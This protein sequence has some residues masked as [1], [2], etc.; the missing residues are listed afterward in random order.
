ME[1]AGGA[2]VVTGAGR[3]TGRTIAL[4]FG[5]LGARVALVARTESE[6]QETARQ[7]KDSGGKALVAPADVTNEEQ[8]DQMAKQ[9]LSAFGTAD[10]L[11][12]NAGIARRGLVESL[13]LA[14]W[15]QVLAVNLTG[16]FLCSR[17]FIPA[18]KQHRRGHIISI[19]SGAGKHGYQS[20]A[21]YS[22]SKFGLI[23]FS[24]SLAAELGDWNIKVATLV[25]GTIDTSFSG[26]KPGERPEGIKML[27]PEDVAQA[28]IGMVRQSEYAWTQ[29]MNLWPFK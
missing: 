7:I 6:L 23:G 21:A 13:S 14:D 15:N 9:V 3:G 25:P 22:A 17:A 28:I 5:R 29:E 27:R 20:L 8:V 2:V 12:N 16:P 4:E 11:V 10:V 18:M 1:I 26:R 24:E 19:S